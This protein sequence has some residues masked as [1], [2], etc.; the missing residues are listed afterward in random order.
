MSNKTPDKFTLFVPDE[1]EP[2]KD[3]PVRLEI[4]DSVPGKRS[5]KAM[6]GGAYNPYERQ[7]SSGDTARM[8]KPRVDLRDL[9]KWIKQ[10]QQVKALKEED[11]P[12]RESD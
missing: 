7:G 3:M 9:S 12:P 4:L 1:K 5:R 2:E 6:I 10:T 8:R 11:V